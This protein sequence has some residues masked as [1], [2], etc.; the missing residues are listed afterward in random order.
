MRLRGAALHA[1]HKVFT[2]RF[3][4]SALSRT[5]GVGASTIE[6]VELSTDGG[7]PDHA[8]Q[9]RVVLEDLLRRCAGEMRVPKKLSLQDLI[10]KERRAPGIH[11]LTSRG[12][13]F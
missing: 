9:L 11:A 5:L 3:S 12:A 7:E 1:Q 4:P 6:A 10:Q 2:K 13:V 8:Q